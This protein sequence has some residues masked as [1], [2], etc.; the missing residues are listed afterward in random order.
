MPQA[1]PRPPDLPPPHQRRSNRGTPAR[2][3]LTDIGDSTAAS[4]T[5]AAPPSGSAT[6]P[7]TSPDHSWRP[8]ASDP[9]YTLDCEEPVM[10]LYL[11]K[12][13]LM[14]NLSGKHW[15]IGVLDTENYPQMSTRKTIKTPFEAQQAGEL[16]VFVLERCERTYARALDDALLTSK[17]ELREW[18]TERQ[19][20]VAAALAA[21]G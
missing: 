8:A 9:N 4:N 7:T 11:P 21:G 20:E 15:T 19:T 16:I 18:F 1:L 14:L 12:A 17:P 2:H 3:D 6:S 13:A 10:L 5:C